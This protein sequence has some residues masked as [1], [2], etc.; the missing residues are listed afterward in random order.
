MGLDPGPAERGRVDP[1]SGRAAGT[2]ALRH[3]CPDDDRGFLSDPDAVCLKP[4]RPLGFH[5]AQWPRPQPVAAKLGHDLSPRDHL[6]GLRRFHCTLR[7]RRGRP[8]HRPL[9]RRLDTGYP[10]LDAHLVAV[11]VHWHRAGSAVG[12]SRAGLGW[13]LGLGPGRERL[14]HAVADRHGLPAL[15]HDPGTARDA[16]GVEP[17]AHPVHLRANAAGHLH[18][19]Q[20]HHRIGACLRSIQS[21]AILSGLHRPDRLR[22]PVPAFPAIGR[23]AG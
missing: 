8:H 15:G 6:P 21:G 20:W 13:L 9:G 19:P 1:A 17:A 18:H 5:P 3:R 16:Q 23:A 10:S 22:L 12:L 2:A 7:F 4:L 11:P 14:T